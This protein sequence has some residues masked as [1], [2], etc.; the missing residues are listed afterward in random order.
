MNRTQMVYDLN[1]QYLQHALGETT[2]LHDDKLI[3][4]TLAALNVR[5]NDDPGEA[6][7]P[8]YVVLDPNGDPISAAISETSLGDGLTVREITSTIIANR[9]AM[10]ADHA[11]LVRLA[12]NGTGGGHVPELQYRPGRGLADRM[13]D[14]ADLTPDEQQA[15][16][17]AVAVQR[18]A[19]QRVNQIIVTARRRREAEVKERKRRAAQMQRLGPKRPIIRP[20]LTAPSIEDAK[21]DAY[22]PEF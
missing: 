5:R 9:E 19:Q 15:A 11:E 3:E 20:H 7:Q 14:F 18:R 10:L 12:Q 21:P 16:R 4:P 22:E 1:K 17:E 6:G 2:L 8:A 13:V